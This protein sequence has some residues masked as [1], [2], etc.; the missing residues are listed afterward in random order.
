M[1]FQKKLCI[2][3]TTFDDIFLWDVTK[4]NAMWY[5]INTRN[6]FKKIFWKP[7]DNRFYKLY[8]AKCKEQYN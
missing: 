8:N 7:V 1:S 6:V 4:L 3:Y 5:N 2:Y